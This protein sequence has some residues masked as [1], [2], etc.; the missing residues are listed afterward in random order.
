[1]NERKN[2][3]T[4]QREKQLEDLSAKVEAAAVTAFINRDDLCRHQ[5]QP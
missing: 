3:R 4:N 5:L 2:K 1:M